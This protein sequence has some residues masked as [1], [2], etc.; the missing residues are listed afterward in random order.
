MSRWIITDIHGCYHSFKALVEQH[1]QLSSKDTLY[2]LGDYISKGPFS[3][4]VL[5]YLMDLKEKGFQLHMLR[6]NHEQ[7]ILNA[8]A[9]ST[10]LSELREKGV[11]TFF[12][13]LDIAHPAD[14][15]E[16]Y[17]LFFHSLDWYLS[18]KE[19][20]LVHAGFDFSA[21]DPFLPSDTLVNIRD[22][23]VDPDKTEGR[24]ILHG[25]S[26]TDL[27]QI[28]SSL[29]YNKELHMSLDAGCVYRNNPKQ[30]YLL[31]LNLDTWQW[32]TQK[33]IDES[34]NYDP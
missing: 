8:L 23:Q 1:L 14:I 29:S 18:L 12:K 5:D 34:D 30:G 9:G 10:S 24:R 27:N 16:R 7:E 6:G 11:F 25:H 17:I 28:I 15:P 4:Q 32:K 20:L 19:W 33:N 13:N 21:P 3:K 31:A 2:L 26:P 22:Y